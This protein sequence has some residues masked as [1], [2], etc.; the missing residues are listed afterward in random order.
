M[1]LMEALEFARNESIIHRERRN[2]L[3]TFGTTRLPYVCLSAQDEQQSKVIVRR[4]EVMAQPPKIALP[5]QHFQF[6][7]FEFD[8]EEE[9]TLEAILL[10]RQIEMPPAQYS[11]NAQGQSVETGPVEAAV[12]RTATQLDKNNDS[13]TA[14]ISTPPEVWNLSILLYVGQQVVRSAPSNVAEHMERLHFRNQRE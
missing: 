10:A 3:Y 9:G 4:G 11:H 6:D 13:R 2:L 7:G 1:N 8:D 12:E 5:G 14:V